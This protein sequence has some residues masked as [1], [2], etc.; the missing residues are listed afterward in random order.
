MAVQYEHRAAP[1]ELKRAEVID[2]MVEPVPRPPHK[3]DLSH[4]TK[5]LSCQVRR[6][7]SRLQ[8]WHLKY[9][10]M[11]MYMACTDACHSAAVADL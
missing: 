2:A 4:A 11:Y 3:V 8:G 7:P 5:T 10:H 1:Q 6:P 9:M